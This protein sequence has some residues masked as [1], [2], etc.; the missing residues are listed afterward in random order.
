MTL[1]PAA[2]PLRGSIKCAL[3]CPVLPQFGR[4]SAASARDHRP[5]GG[6]GR[7]M[8][9]FYTR[10][11]VLC[12]ALGGASLA[13]MASAVLIY[14]TLPQERAVDGAIRAL[15]CAIVVSFPMI[16][17]LGSQMRHNQALSRELQYSIDFDRLTKVATRAQFFRRLGA[18]EAPGGGVV[19]MMDVDHFKRVNDTHGHLVGDSVLAAVA[20]SIDRVT[21]R[22]DLVARFGGEEFV[23]FIPGATLGQGEA[24]AERVR[25]AVAWTHVPAAPGGLVSPTISVGVATVDPGEQIDAAIQRADAALYEAKRAGRNRVILSPNAPPL[26]RAHG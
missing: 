12:F 7:D 6:L 20:A 25:Q 21:R 14:A 18:G 8:F 3:F 24:I 9:T 16:L 15:V 11:D 4:M 13:A 2:G 26:K 1:A 5:R 19:M 17:F 23:V 22:G 10:R